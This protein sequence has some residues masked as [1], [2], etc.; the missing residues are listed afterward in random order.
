MRQWRWL[1][2]VL[3]ILGAIVAAVIHFIIPLKPVQGSVVA[4]LKMIDCTGILLS[5]SATI[6]LLIPISSGGSTFAWSGSTTI[7][8][9][10]SGAICVTGFVATEAKVAKLPILPCEP[11]AVCSLFLSLT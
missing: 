9:L 7:G 1:F 5:S 10:V 8:L 2:R 11:L 4:K 3:A 6:F